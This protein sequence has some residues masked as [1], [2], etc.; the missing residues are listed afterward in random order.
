M[1]VDH[2][3]ASWEP[4]E[5]MKLVDIITVDKYA[6]TTVRRMNMGQNGS[7]SYT[8]IPKSIDGSSRS[9]GVY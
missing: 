2:C 7:E 9:L 6:M 8:K 1:N 5:D 4:I 3:N